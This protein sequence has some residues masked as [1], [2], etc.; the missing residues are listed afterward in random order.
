MI[1][2]AFPMSLGRRKPSGFSEILPEELVQKVP[3]TEPA[4]SFEQQFG[5]CECPEV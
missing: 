2:S 4:E 3:L 1:E 5:H